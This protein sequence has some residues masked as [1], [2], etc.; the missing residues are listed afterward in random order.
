[1]CEP[2]R[3]RLPPR[4]DQEI[5][6]VDT[7]CRR[8]EVL[9][10]HAHLVFAQLPVLRGLEH[11]GKAGRQQRGRGVI[12]PER[13]MP[14]AATG[15]VRDRQHPSGGAEKSIQVSRSE[16][17]SCASS[18]RNTSA[19]GSSPMRG[20][21][22]PS[23]NK[24]RSGSLEADGQRA[25]AR[26]MMD[27]AMF[28]PVLCPTTRISSSRPSRMRSATRAA[29]ASGLEVGCAA[30]SLA[31]GEDVASHQPAHVEASFELKGRMHPGTEDR[32]GQAW[33]SQL[34]AQR[35]QRRLRQRVQLEHI[36]GPPSQTPQNGMEQR[37]DSPM[38]EGQ[39]VSV[40]RS[41]VAA[42]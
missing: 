1:M 27:T 2:V 16:A 12:W 7:F 39:R 17:P 22:C 4:R 38:R 20:M 36:D 28:E 37:T 26:A 33:Q 23:V 29:R 24:A 15:S 34:A 30:R 11:L 40:V 8:H 13:S 18:L 3:K 19:C 6:I 5:V 9:E 10:V 21:H 31:H 14:H 42:V 25:I 35:L 41:M 32:S